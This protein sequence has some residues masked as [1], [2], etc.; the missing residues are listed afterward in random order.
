MKKSIKEFGLTNL[1]V[2]NKVSVYIL[3]FIIFLIGLSSYISMPKESFPEIKQPQFYINTPYPGNSPLDMENLVTRPIEREINGITGL[4]KLSS[5]SIQDFSIIIVDFEQDVVIEEALLDVKDAVDRAKS[6]LPSDLPADPN[7]MEMDFSQFPIL[8]VNVSGDVPIEDLKENAEYLEEKIEDLP[9]VSGVDISGLME[10]EVQVNVDL[11]ELEAI[12]LSLD[13][14]I[15]AIQ[16]EN[17]TVSGGDIKV[18][19]GLGLTRRNIRIDG[20]FKHYEELNNVIV[21]SNNQKPVYLKD[22]AEVKFGPKEANSYARLD[23]K[24]VVTLDVK[25]KTGKNLLNA[26]DKITEIIEEANESHFPKS[27]HAMITNDQSKFTRS[28]VNNLE[29]SIIMGIILVV[30]VLLFFLGV[31]NAMF[32]GIAIPLSMMMGIGILNTAG[33]TLNMMVLFSLILALGMLV[34]N[35][36]VVVENIFRLKNE[37]VDGDT[38]SKQGVGEVATAIISS[39]ATTLAAFLPLLFWNDLMGEFM[40]YLPIT[41]IIVLSSSLFVALVVNPVLTSQFMLAG[42]GRKKASR[43]FNIIMGVVLLLGLLFM[44]SDGSRLFGT[45]L[46]TTF[47]FLMVNKYL[48]EPGAAKFQETVMPKLENAYS[49][50]A[51]FALKGGRPIGFFLGTFVLMIVSIQIFKMSGPEVV[52]FPDNQPRTVSVFITTPLGTDIDRT[53][54]ITMELEQKVKEAIKP[55]RNIVEAVLAQVGEKT[56]DPNEGPQ[57][58]SSPHKA[59]ITVSFYDYEDRIK[60]SEVSTSEVM[61][62]IRDAVKDY[63][64]ASITVDKDKN[65]PP[66]GKPINV[67]VSGENYIELIAYVEKLKKIMENANVSGIDQLKTDLELGKPELI[68]TPNRDAAMR[69]GVSTQKIATTVRDALFGREATKYKQGEDD[70]EVQVRLKDKYRYNLNTLLNMKVSLGPNKNIPISALADI[71]YSS[72]YGAVKRL[73]MDRVISIFSNVKEGANANTI[74]ADLKEILDKTPKK[75]GYSY[76]FTGEQQEQAETMNFLMGAFVVAFL[77]IFLIIVTQFNSVISPFIIMFSVLFSTIG[78]FLGFSI[79]KMDFS[80]LMSGIGIIS[81]AGVVVNNAIVLIDYINLLRTRKR[82]EMGLG[83]KDMLPPDVI[84]H[85][86]VEGGKTRLRPVLL[87]AITTVLGLIPLAI[88]MNINFFTLFSDFDPQIYFGGDNV[89]FWGP[90]AWTI[91]FGLVFATFLTL[92]IVPVMYLM[93]DQLAAFIRRTLKKV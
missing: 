29:N 71:E 1:S 78:V 28:M 20:E 65:G 46:V 72:T 25:K 33:T 85:T 86:I 19:D 51:K 82:E 55:S 24:T 15:K 90:M 75:E 66:V 4:K 54:E 84:V 39:T 67:E 37:G 93:S 6:E 38:A 62:D 63:P 88:G 80:I 73:D 58:G 36:I 69:F 60:V 34:D 56:A 32:V 77:L 74:V 3:V 49:R 47:I 91:I 61:E 44:I 70:Y 45:L 48:L 2:D 21:K 81:L 59:R 16:D 17:K 89:S 64:E 14:V 31:R 27:I 11:A 53:N 18:I 79:T 68:V 30:L 10:N 26:A 12:K 42:N 35:G 50:F 7:V 40:K 52:F 8:N 87:T 5:T 23:G 92:I 13:D 9:E 41:L 43:K 57:Q 83:P 22:I 76:K